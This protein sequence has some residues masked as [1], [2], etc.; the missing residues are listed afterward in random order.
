MALFNTIRFILTFFLVLSACSIF[1]MNNPVHSVLFLILNFCLASL[2]ILIYEVKFLGLLFVMVY[3]GAV[4]VLF[5]FVVMM[6]NIK[7]EIKGK[8]TFL[9]IYIIILSLLIIFISIYTFFNENFVS[10]YNVLNTFKPLKYLTN[11]EII[12][13]ILYNNYYF[14]F[15]IGGFILLVALVGSIV[16]TIHFK[17]SEELDKSYAQLSRTTL[18]LSKIKN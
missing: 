7:D 5:L 9:K 15:L 4:A 1:L 2:I 3:V 13:Q 17:D 6:L 14:A 10:N 16:L 11:T 18:T 12:G 8:L